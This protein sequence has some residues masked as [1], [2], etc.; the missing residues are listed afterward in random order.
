G[1][2]RSAH[3]LIKTLSESADLIFLDKSSEY[4]E[5]ASPLA[6][7]MFEEELFACEIYNSVVATKFRQPFRAEL[8]I[9]LE[10]D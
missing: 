2:R 6:R 8:S 3:T 7:R 4:S 10:I 1:L 5:F 9:P